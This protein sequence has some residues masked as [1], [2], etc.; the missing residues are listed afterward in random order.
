MTKAKTSGRKSGT[1][2]KPVA[3]KYPKEIV[4]EALQTTWVLKGYLK[5]VQLYHLRIGARLA[6]VRDQKLYAALKHPTIEAYA[7]ER[8]GLGRSS[9]YSYVNAYE[10][11]AKSHPAWLKSKPKGFIPDLSDIGDLMWIEEELAKPDLAA[12]RKAALEKLR[13]KGLSGKLLRSEVR[14]FRR[15][16]ATPAD[17]LEDFLTDLQNLRKEA[18]AISDIPP[19]AL[20]ELD[21]AIEILKKQNSSK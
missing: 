20:S 17:R 7:Q 6:R 11:V 21:S 14:P 13:R 18:A 15:E 3:A 4:Q 8:L 12:D 19:A 16:P 2:A 1:A 10:W 9:L 5:N